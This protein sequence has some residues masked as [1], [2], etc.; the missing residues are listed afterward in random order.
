LFP[1][2][3]NPRKPDWKMLKEHLH[4]EGRLTKEDLKAVVDEG[5]K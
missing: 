1:D 2:P 3:K 5:N 4:R